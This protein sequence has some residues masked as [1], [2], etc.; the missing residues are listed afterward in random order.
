MNSRF[1]LI[2]DSKTEDTLCAAIILN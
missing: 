1:A 2:G